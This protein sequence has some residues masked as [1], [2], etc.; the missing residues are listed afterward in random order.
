MTRASEC[1]AQVRLFKV[2]MSQGAWVL[3]V[4]L[5]AATAFGLYRAARDGRFRG[6]HA[7]RGA[8]SLRG[9]RARPPTE[10]PTARA[11]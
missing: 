1:A 8:A 3:V 9:G 2:H 10:P 7:V 5:V 4:A 6:T 11:R